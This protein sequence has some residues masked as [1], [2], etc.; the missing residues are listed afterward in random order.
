MATG[1]IPMKKK[2]LFFVWQLIKNNMR[3][4]DDRTLTLFFKNKS[5]AWYIGYEEELSTYYPET[6][7]YEYDFC[8]PDIPIIYL[9]SKTVSTEDKKFFLDAIEQAIKLKAD[10]SDYLEWF[11]YEFH[12]AKKVK[13]P[14]CRS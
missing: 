2:R 9:K 8:I 14:K 6:K 4:N 11:N 3:K 12:M 10:V 7:E 13:C 1:G 5:I